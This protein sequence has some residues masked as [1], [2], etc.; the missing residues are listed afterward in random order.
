[1]SPGLLHGWRRTAGSA[2][3]RPASTRCEW[4]PVKRLPRTCA[5]SFRASSATMLG[6]S[7]SGHAN[8]EEV[9]PRDAETRA[10]TESILRERAQVGVRADRLEERTGALQAELDK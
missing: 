9:R 5:S 7:I 1:M 3:Q 2:T 8:L 4:L 6:C 10:Q